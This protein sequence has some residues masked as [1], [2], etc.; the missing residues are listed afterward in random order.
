MADD[1]KGIWKDAAGVAPT[2]TSSSPWARVLGDQGEQP[3]QPELPDQP[4]QPQAPAPR[5]RRS[6]GGLLH[7]LDAGA[8]RFTAATVLCILAWAVLAESIYGEVIPWS[9]TEPLA[10]AL[11]AGAACAVATRLA[12][13][14][15]DQD[16]RRGWLEFA[17]PA[18]VTVVLAAL[19][20]AFQD[21]NRIE[22]HALL[23][24]G[25]GLSSAFAALWVLYDEQ[26]ERT[27]FAE[28]VRGVGFASLMSFMLSVG[29]V[30]LYLAIDKLLGITL[31]KFLE[32]THVTVGVLVFPVLVLSQLPRTGDV[33]QPGR[34]YRAVMGYV[35][36]PLCLALLAILYGYIVRI[37]IEGQMP[38]GV[39][40][41]FGSIALLVEICLWL[42]LRPIENRVARLFVRWGWALLVPVV[43]VQLYGVAVRFAAYGLTAWRYAG[44][45]CLVVGL[46]SLVLAAWQQHPRRLFS[47][48]AVVCAIVC[49]TPLNAIDAANLHQAARLGDALAQSDSQTA[50]GSWDYLRY[51]AR[52][53]FEPALPEDVALDGEF[54]DEFGM[55][56]PDGSEEQRWNYWSTDPEPLDVAGFSRLYALDE[57]DRVSDETLACTYTW[58]DGTTLTVS[59]VELVEWLPEEPG[60]TMARADMTLELD[61]GSVVVL[62]YL[63]AN[64]S[65]DEITDIYAY[66]WYLVP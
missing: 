57:A 65:G 8:K 7:Q 43:A 60:T 58:S 2:G 24:V 61:D 9:L 41:W 34:A 39:M 30:I 54:E 44:M 52:G 1:N 23:C 21:T 62:T 32:T 29:L 31:V 14:R 28:L 38:S 40:N 66:G 37:L 63:E 13:E 6:L 25:V 59:F 49:V 46:F 22:F 51:S 47:F 33:P 27:L 35:V 56:V 17:L 53:Y 45:A 15:Y 12:L 5:P 36:L 10:L 48:A 11:V 18:A 55:P 42:G 26:S 19:A 64:Y 4:E 16:G 3:E 20:W 50:Y